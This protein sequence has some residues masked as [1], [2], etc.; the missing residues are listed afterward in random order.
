VQ[1]RLVDGNAWCARALSEIKARVARG[2]TVKVVFDIDDTLSDGRAR[3]LAI[4]KAFDEKHGTQ[5]FEGVG[6]DRML[7]DA[8]DTAASLG[9]GSP[10]KEKFERFWDKEFWSPKAFAHDE[11]FADTVKLA[12]DAAKAGAKVIYLTGR[13]QHLERATIEQLQ[14]FGLPQVD[15]R[16]VVSKPTIKTPTTPWRAN[17]LA[18]N[19]PKETAFFITE[20]RRDIA[21]VQRSQ[22][23]VPCVLFHSPFNG[24][25]PVD[26]GTP[27]FRAR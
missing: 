7:H 24:E 9:I 25:T 2:E 27:I 8:I 14:R 18:T 19:A 11:P 22:G 23:K 1:P 26:E 21:G 17:W 13:V 3:T 16:H 10:L 20:S 4:G 12:H 6:K 5:F 15:A